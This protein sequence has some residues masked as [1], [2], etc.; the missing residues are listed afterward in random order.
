M[1]SIVQLSRQERIRRIGQLLSK[2]ITL[3]LA[4]E[5]DQKQAVDPEPI[6][7]PKEASQV[8]R[9]G[10]GQADLATDETERAILD[11]LEK[12]EIASPREIQRYLDLS[13]A[14]TYRK[15]NRLVSAQFLTRS[16]STT[17]VRYRLAPDLR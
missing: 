14:T 2:G 7:S 17:S 8:G 9:N 13:K 6:S 16:G 3:L 1:N 4:R 5:D 11:Y 10:N 15:L 12:I